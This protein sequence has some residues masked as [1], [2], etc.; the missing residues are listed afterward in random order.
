MATE[1]PPPGSGR[2]DQATPSD[3]SSWPPE[4]GG[5]STRIPISSYRCGFS[6]LTWGLSSAA[7]GPPVQRNWARPWALWRTDPFRVFPWP[8][9]DDTM[10]DRRPSTGRQ[11]IDHIELSIPARAALLH[12]VRLTAGVVAA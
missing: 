12:L 11:M 10:R 8:S 6:R 4:W 9:G 2:P 5:Q 3:S 7:S 1:G